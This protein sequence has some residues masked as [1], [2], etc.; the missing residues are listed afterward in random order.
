MNGGGV[1]IPKKN[2]G[3]GIVLISIIAVVLIIG[4]FAGTYW[5]GLSKRASISDIYRVQIERSSPEYLKLR[6]ATC[7]ELNGD[8]FNQDNKIGCFDIGA[9]WDSSWCD[10][11]EGTKVENICNSINGA[12]W[13]CQ[14]DV[15]GC[16][17]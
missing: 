5:W 17:Y 16:K 3:A 10:S 13:L 12:E 4:V 1:K 6:E 11:S 14:L 15:I 7:V 8:W 2:K 9:D